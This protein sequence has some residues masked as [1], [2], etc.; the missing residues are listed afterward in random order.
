MK[1]QPRRTTTSWK[2]TL[3]AA[4]LGAALCLA[5]GAGSCSR[6]P[7]AG[8]TTAGTGAP[9]DELRVH[10][11]V[12]VDSKGTSRAVLESTEEGGARLVFLGKGNSMAATIGVDDAGPRIT[13]GDAG[14]KPVAEFGLSKGG[15]PALLLRDAKARRRIGLMVAESGAA[16]LSLFDEAGVNRC[17]LDLDRDGTAYLA[18]GDLPKAPRI[19]I[20][21]G[22]GGECA[23]GLSDA[24]GTRATLELDAHGKATIAL[25]GA[26]QKAVWSQ[27]TP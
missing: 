8:A 15:A 11:L 3:G 10:K 9:Q 25:L 16:G 23:V 22:E 2:R 27:T 13:I 21:V 4:R 17:R 18:L 20:S 14:D 6:A 1:A 24:K 7:Q 26:D 5:V 12:L 19:T